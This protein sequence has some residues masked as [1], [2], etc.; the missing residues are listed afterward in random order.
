MEATYTEQIIENRSENRFS[1]RRV[2]MLFQLYYPLLKKQMIF[3]PI[4]SALAVLLTAWLIKVNEVTSIWDQNF[5]FA[6]WPMIM[7]SIMFY[8]APIGLARRDMRPLCAMLPV[9]VAEKMT[10]LILYFWIGVM[11]LTS[12]AVYL[13]AFVMI[14]FDPMMWDFIGNAINSFSNILGFSVWSIWGWIMA[15][16]YQAIVMLVVI[17]ASRNRIL[18]GILT[19]FGVAIA[20]GIISGISGM[21]WAIYM[22]YQNGKGFAQEL[23]TEEGDALTPA[24]AE[25]MDKVLTPIVIL[26]AI[27]LAWVLWA[28]YKK[29]RYSGI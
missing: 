12:G 1:W 28:I 3:F 25:I 24:M 21:I 4:L 23:I 19:Y 7:V 20:S 27:A 15:W 16:T 29:L 14:P 13:T 8:L 18:W 2:W 6:G 26:S 22:I 17:S 10:F 11:L 9:T 5:G